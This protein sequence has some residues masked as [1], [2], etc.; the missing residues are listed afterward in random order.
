MR[1]AGKRVCDV[2]DVLNLNTV[3]HHWIFVVA[4]WFGDVTFFE[5]L[6]VTADEVNR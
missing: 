1:A 3:R 2:Q 6:N 4:F 5:V